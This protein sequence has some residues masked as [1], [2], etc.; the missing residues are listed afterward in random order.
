MTHVYDWGLSVPDTVALVCP[1]CRGEAEMK[2]AV[3]PRSSE[4]PPIAGGYVCGGC[5]AFGDRTISWPQDAYLSCEIRGERLWAWNREHLVAIRDFVASRHRDWKGHPGHAI[6]LLH[7]PTHFLHAK[8][9]DDVVAA[10]GRLL[11][12]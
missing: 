3:L 12:K 2:V 9:R 7:L 6:E 1:A 5:G 10:I 11:S 8:H 4:R